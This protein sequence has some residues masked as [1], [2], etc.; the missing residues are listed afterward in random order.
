MYYK[1]SIINFSFQEV[2][3]SFEREREDYLRPVIVMGVETEQE[4][5]SVELR[6]FFPKTISP[7]YLHFGDWTFK[8]GVA[9]AR[10]V[11]SSL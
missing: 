7:A 11:L 8:W 4:C 9:R 10:V 5:S 3:S 1:N 6:E 2:C